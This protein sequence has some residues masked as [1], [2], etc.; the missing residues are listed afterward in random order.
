MVLVDGLALLVTPVH[1]TARRVSQDA[2]A[3]DPAAHVV[4]AVGDV[5]SV[6]LDGAL[7][8]GLVEEGL[9]RGHACIAFC[10]IEVDYRTAQDVRQW[11]TAWA[12]G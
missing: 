7:L 5:R 2:D 11:A 10:F 1:L 3:L 8:G 12:E 9:L 4:G 6:E